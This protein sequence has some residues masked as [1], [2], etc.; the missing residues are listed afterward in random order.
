MYRFFIPRVFMTSNRSQIDLG[1]ISPSCILHYSMV[2]WR[3]I[4]QTCIPELS[5]ASK[6]AIYFSPRVSFR[7]DLKKVSAQMRI[8]SRPEISDRP[9][10]PKRIQVDLSFIS[11][12]SHVSTC[13]KVIFKYLRIFVFERT[14]TWQ[15]RKTD[16]I[17]MTSS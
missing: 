15:P 14:M 3:Q 2:K 7:P 6:N 4:Y 12:H 10:Q 9:E 13:H 11:P 5:F 16:I 8:S 17:K 1:K